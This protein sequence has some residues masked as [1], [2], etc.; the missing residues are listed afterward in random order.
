[1]FGKGFAVAPVTTDLHR[2]LLWLGNEGLAAVVF[3]DGIAVVTGATSLDTGALDLV[4]LRKA[5][6]AYRPSGDRA[7]LFYA[8]YRQA[9]VSYPSGH[10]FLDYAL[11][12]LGRQAGFG[13]SVAHQNYGFLDWADWVAALKEDRGSE[14]AEAA[15]GDDRVKAYPVRTPL[16]RKLTESA[17][18]VVF[19]RTPLDPRRDDWVPAEVEKSVRAAIE[20]LKLAKGKKVHFQFNI[21]EQDEQ[22]QE[23]VRAVARRWAADHNLELGS[24]GLGSFGD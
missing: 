19:V 21:R 20:G 16:S 9:R 11:E 5:L 1:V 10:R 6:E 17:D 23:R 4:A 7:V 12:G 2:R 18:A 8:S 15:V 14:E 13:R 3:V 24:F 22:T